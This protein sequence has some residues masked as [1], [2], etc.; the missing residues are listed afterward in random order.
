M[1]EER[2]AILIKENFETVHRRFDQVD[3]RFDQTDQKIFDLN[4][5]LQSI[6][7]TLARLNE[8][9]NDMSGFAKEIDCLSERISEIESHLGIGLKI[10]A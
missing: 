8:R 9:V 2:L 7:S 10:A 6:K 5:E 4:S 1:N 3:A